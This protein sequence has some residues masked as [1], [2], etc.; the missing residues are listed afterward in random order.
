MKK[1]EIPKKKFAKKKSTL[2]TI[3]LCDK[4]SFICLSFFLSACTA[5]T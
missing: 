4:L 1:G 5:A 3:N 2:E